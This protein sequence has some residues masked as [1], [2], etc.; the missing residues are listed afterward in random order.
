MFSLSILSISYPSSIQFTSYLEH[1]SSSQYVV[2]LSDLNFLSSSAGESASDCLNAVD[3]FTRGGGGFAFRLA[4]ATALHVNL[5]TV[6]I[7]SA[8]DTENDIAQFP[9]NAEL[10]AV[11]SALTASTPLCSSGTTQLRGHRLSSTTLTT[12]NSSVALQVVASRATALA[13]SVSQ[14]NVTTFASI[15]ACK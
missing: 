10:L 3:W 7:E 15:Y 4:M 9:D 14:L 8:S 13:I 12:L 1:V 2:V 6:N 5:S 11:N